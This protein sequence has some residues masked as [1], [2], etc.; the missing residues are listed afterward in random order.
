MAVLI[1]DVTAVLKK[2]IMPFVRDNFPQE[3]PLLDQLKRNEGVTFMN[4]NFY[5]PVRTQRSGGVVN[6]AD[7]GNSINPVSDT[8]SQASVGV[9]IMTGAFDIS[10]LTIEATRTTKGAVTNELTRRAKSLVSDFA[11]SANR[12]YFSDGYGVL[13]QVSATGTTNV[14]F[15]PPDSS[16]DDGRVLDVYGTI[17]ADVS[18]VEYIYP[19]QILGMGSAGNTH[20]TVSSVT[21]NGDGTGT[22]TFTGAS[23][24]TA[25]DPVYLEDADNEGAG[26]AEIQGM[27]LALSSSSGTSTYAGVARSTQGWSPQL[28][29][30]AE[31]LSLSEMELRYLQ[32]R[33]FAQRGDRYAIF[34]NITLYKKYG[35]LL[36]A[37][38]RTVNATD[39]LGGWTGLEFAAGGGRVGVFLDYDVPD[40]EVLIVNLDSWT[41]CQVSDMGWLE[42]PSG[43]G[44]LRLQ[45][46][47]KYQ[48]VMTWFT[49]LICTA[50]G[51]NGRLTQK[52]D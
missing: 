8:T 51:A 50:P 36:T 38:R 34:V 39:L 27:R 32:A 29:T 23:I 20:G 33:K 5:A 28:G 35:D 14:K 1:S 2:V 11:K 4:D 19:G 45:N 22:V 46:T 7:D 9:K 40:G 30:A 15:T 12:Q 31:A 18:A 3:T 41:V 48:A 42:D 10:K 37:L 43:G 25:N 47:I 24:G 52:T 49:N 21:D 16:L 6:L 26:T 44:I 17:N 13:A